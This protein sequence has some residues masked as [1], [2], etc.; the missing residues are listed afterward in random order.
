MVS[1]KANSGL[2]SGGNHPTGKVATCLNE[3]YFLTLVDADVRLLVLTNP[4]F[5]ALSTRT[6][7]GQIAPGIG[8]ESLPL[9][10]D[11][12]RTVDGIT[13]LAREMTRDTATA[14]SAVE[15]EEAGERGEDVGSVNSDS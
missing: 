5:H 12:Q 15:A 14:A 8:V 3:V 11:M 9:P 13:E 7:A 10:S 4:G 2:T 1:I 6:T